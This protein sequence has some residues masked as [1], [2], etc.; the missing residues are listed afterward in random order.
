MALNEAFVWMTTFE[1]TPR[2]VNLA[3]TAD[4]SATPAPPNRCQH[5][6]GLVLHNQGCEQPASDQRYSLGST[7]LACNVTRFHS[8]IRTM[9]VRCLLPTQ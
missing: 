3:C 1:S 4:R 2:E 6:L 8:T 5:F 7:T 9:V